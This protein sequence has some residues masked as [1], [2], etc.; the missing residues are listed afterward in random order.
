MNI[1]TNIKKFF[2]GDIESTKE[3]LEKYSTDASL[4]KV[5]PKLVVF[6]KDSL[7]IQNLVQWVKDNKE[8]DPSLSL[9]VRA[10]GTCMSG[11]P[12]ND[13]IIMD[14]TRY[15]NTIGEVIP[16]KEYEHMPKYPGAHA[17]TI[18]GEVTL[19]PGVFYR[20]LETKTFEKDLVLP[21]FT[22]S[23]SIN[24]IGGMVG[25][26]SAGELTL[27]YGKTE[28]YVKE[29]KVIFA[30]GH[31]YIVKPLTR[32]EMYLKIAESTFEGQVY[33]QMFDLIK[34][35]KSMIAAAKPRVTKNSAGYNLWNIVSNEGN[36]E[37]VFDLSQVIIGAQGTLGIVTEV[38][39]RLVKKPGLSKLAVVFMDD[40]D[41]LGSVVKE[42]LTTRPLTLESYDDKT[43]GL[44]MKF[45]KDF[46]KAKGFFGTI[47]FGL[48]FIPEFF[49]VL[50]GGV[51]KLILLAEYEGSS[52]EEIDA[53]CQ[54]LKEMMKK[55]N[56]KT[57]VTKSPKEAKKYWDMRRDSFALLRKHV[58]GRHTAPF[59]DDIIVRPE[60]LP[61]FLPKLNAILNEYDNMMYTIAG[62]AGNG[63]F[64][65][66]PLMDFNDA[67]T[68][69]TIF[70]VSER[71]YDLVI[72]YEGS[73]DAEH[74]D[75]IIRTPYL[76]KMFGIGICALFQT[77]K[78]IF[79]PKNIF[80]PHK[81]VGEEKFFLQ[82]HIIQPEKEKHTS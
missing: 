58:A 60:F 1:E 18:S 52:M 53:K 31:E 54:A 45:F 47:G 41:Q 39:L 71:V 3:V 64:H 15:M 22:A 79:D 67:R 51:P 46:V 29:M 56:L 76:Q 32:R 6:P 80:N 69:P 20:D 59:I 72:Q 26:N 19:Q 68:V 14:V 12:L 9:T 23:K 2:K 28:D 63:N 10:A 16:V 42:I 17:V 43:F 25:N 38:T 11:G 48:Q 27:Q 57:H 36:D 37:E 74:N 70:E 49:M 40:L 4:L 77:T 50:T 35:H 24:A 5:R 8:K 78:D 13:S 44:A 33:K 61:E 30:D 66:I 75:G 73:I 62:H 34:D 82:E 21:C 81:K 55:F 65:I 7:D